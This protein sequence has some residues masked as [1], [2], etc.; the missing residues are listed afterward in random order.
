MELKE[1]ECEILEMPPTPNV[2]KDLSLVLD[3]AFR[4]GS[5]ES[6]AFRGNHS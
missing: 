5:V 3:C 1:C 6:N 4:E 2:S